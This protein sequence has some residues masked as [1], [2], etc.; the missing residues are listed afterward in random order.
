VAGSSIDVDAIS[1]YPEAQT[2]SGDYN[3]KVILYDWPELEE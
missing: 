3:E 1:V 2:I